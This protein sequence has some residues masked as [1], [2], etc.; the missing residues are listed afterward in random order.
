M[1]KYGDPCHDFAHVL[2]VKNMAMKL[3]TMANIKNK[4]RLQTIEIAALLHDVADHKF[5]EKDENRDEIITDLLENH[6][7]MKQIDTI[8][9]IVKNVSYTNEITIGEEEMEKIVGMYPDLVFVQ[10]ADRLDAVGAIGVLRASSYG[11]YKNRPLQK[12]IDHFDEKLFKL[13]YYVKTD[14]AKAIMEERI[15]FMK[16]FK[17]QYNHEKFNTN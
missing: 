6:L 8:C 2:R 5:A 11:G 14:A 15:K 17:V 9:N 10:D 4:Y 7:D 3:A 1:K 13:G 12:S 16:M